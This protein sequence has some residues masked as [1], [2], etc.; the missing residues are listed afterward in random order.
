ML[1]SDDFETR[2]HKLRQFPLDVAHDLRGP[3]AGIGMLATTAQKHLQGDDV[4]AVRDALQRIA[5]QVRSSQQVLDALWRLADQLGRPLGSLEL[6]WCSL[7]EVAQAAADEAQLAVQA[8][9][10]GRRLPVLHLRP[11]GH[12]RVDLGLVHVILVNLIGN[13]LKFNL[14]QDAVHVH[15]SRDEGRSDALVL[16][17]VDDGVGFDGDEKADEGPFRQSSEQQAA[18]PGGGWGLSIVRRAV[19]L[20]GGRLEMRAAPGRGARARV[21]L[22]AV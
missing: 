5:H 21:V 7:D 10:P 13:A 8:Q 1:N 18:V 6:G 3:L 19:D 9:L 22:P 15:V 14:D 4:D 20:M 16:D 11:L 2:L 17:V 12:A